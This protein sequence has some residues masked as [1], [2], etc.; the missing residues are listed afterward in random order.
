[1]SSRTTSPAIMVLMVL[2]AAAPLAA[3]LWCGFQWHAWHRASAELAKLGAAGAAAEDIRAE[4]AQVQDRKAQL[5]QQVAGLSAEL[6]EARSRQMPLTVETTQQTILDVLNLAARCG[7]H[8]KETSR[9]DDDP[10]ATGG[11]TASAARKKSAAFLGRFS[12]GKVVR[13][14][15][16][17]EAGADYPAIHRF[18]D[19]LGSLRWMVTP[20]QFD[21]GRRRGTVSV[22]NIDDVPGVTTYSPESSALH[23]TLIVVL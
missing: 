10:A 9:L 1:M 23:L 20:V 21:I 5:T 19:E 7:L 18:L 12:P 3:A 6:A 4:A 14:L 8:V 16:K 13:P 11:A 15:V 22:G 17:I 2:C